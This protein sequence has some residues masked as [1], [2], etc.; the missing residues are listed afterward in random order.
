[1]NRLTWDHKAYLVQLVIA[2]MTENPNRRQTILIEATK[3]QD[4]KLYDYA[5]SLA[6][7]V[8]Y[9]EGQSPLQ[10]WVDQLDDHFENYVAP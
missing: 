3:V 7:K 1:M 5:L 8:T 6:G 2:I 4:Q 10:F 9:V